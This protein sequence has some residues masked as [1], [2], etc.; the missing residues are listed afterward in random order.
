MREKR[1]ELIR[2]E[3]SK[4]FWE[5]GESVGSINV[6][7]SMIQTIFF[8]AMNNLESLIDEMPKKSPV[9]T[10]LTRRLNL[11]QSCY[12]NLNS[13]FKELDR[14]FCSMFSALDDPNAAPKT[15]AKARIDEWK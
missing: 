15:L 8:K 6:C 2:A 11:M 3:E 14:T 1:E 5:F 10:D 9:K 4:I 7:Q 13:H 12:A